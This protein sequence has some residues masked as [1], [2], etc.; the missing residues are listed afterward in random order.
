MTLQ[1]KRGGIYANSTTS[2]ASLPRTKEGWA[3]LDSLSN[4]AWERGT[5]RLITG[6]VGNRRAKKAQGVTPTYKGYPRDQGE[7]PSVASV[8]DAIPPL[9]AW[10]SI[11]FYAS[12]TQLQLDTE[13]VLRAQ[14]SI[15][16][17]GAQAVAPGHALSLELNCER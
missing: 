6:V 7:S 9:P 3:V 16:L 1:Y 17:R 10:N 5:V 12:L 15:F 13:S 4:L 8:A 14:S 11:E 2:V